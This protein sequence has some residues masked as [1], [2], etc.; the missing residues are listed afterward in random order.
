MM[1]NSNYVGY[2]KKV[3]NSEWVIRSQASWKQDEGSTTR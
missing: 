1:A 3:A 2:G